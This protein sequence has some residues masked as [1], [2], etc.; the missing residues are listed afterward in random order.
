MS[1]Y[2]SNN[3]EKHLEK[4]DTTVSNKDNM[5]L[6]WIILICVKSSFII[7]AFT[8]YYFKN[9]IEKK[10]KSSPPSPRPSEDNNKKNIISINIE[11]E[12]NDDYDYTVWDVIEKTDYSTEKDD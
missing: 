1:N 9:D 12:N 11:E 6:G 2:F 4:L 5:N 8:K 7:Y 10:S 3:L